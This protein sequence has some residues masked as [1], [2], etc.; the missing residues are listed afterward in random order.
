VTNLRVNPQTYF[1]RI[2]H[3]CSVLNLLLWRRS[4]QGTSGTYYDTLVNSN[5]CD[6]V[7][8]TI[9][10]IHTPL[11]VSTAS[12]TSIC[13]TQFATLRAYGIGTFSWST[14]LTGASVQVNPTASTLYNVTLTDT[15]G[16][17]S[18]ASMTVNVLPLPVIGVFGYHC[19]CSY[20]GLSACNRRAALFVETRRRRHFY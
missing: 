4:A 19:L 2:V 14:G 8:T 11:P 5:A 7:L 16:C 20:S 6:G 13:R 1:S 15:N 10:I 17:T 9:L 18:T 12:D 3:R